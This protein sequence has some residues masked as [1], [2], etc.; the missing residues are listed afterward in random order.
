MFLLQF[1]GFEPFL[2]TN[3]KSVGWHVSYLNL[4][5]YFMNQNVGY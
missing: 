5:I 1:D 4:T 2:N 3:F